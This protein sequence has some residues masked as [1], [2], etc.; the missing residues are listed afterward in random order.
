MDDTLLVRVSA[1]GPAAA[2]GTPRERGPD[3]RSVRTRAAVVEAAT[4]LF[5]R[6]GYLGTS[7]EDIAALAAVSKR[8]V[9]NNFQDKERLFT[10]IVIGVTA[11]AER[12]ADHLLG[13][14]SDAPDVP[15]A[16]GELARRHLAAITAPQV[17]RLRRLVVSEASRFPDLA[18][19]YHRR[20]PGR[21]L[22]ALAD[23]FAALH[24]RGELAA[25]DPVRAAEH[26]SFLVLGA[27]LDRAMF[28]PESEPPAAAELERVADDAVRVFLAAYR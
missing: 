19:E 23:A 20:A 7:V 21:V 6:H 16:L 5:L 4:T 25:P 27:A 8:T 28:D 14:L 11:T 12:F 15:A 1:T 17:V 22:A 10:E 3:P 13:A 2:Q 26:F 9:Y 18:R 24:E